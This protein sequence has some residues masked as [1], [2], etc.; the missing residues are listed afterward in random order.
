MFS[1]PFVDKRKLFVMKC[2]SRNSTLF[3][4]RRGPWLVLNQGVETLI[5]AL[6][7][8]CDAEQGCNQ[9]LSS[10]GKENGAVQLEVGSDLLLYILR[11]LQSIIRFDI[12][13]ISMRYTENI[14]VIFY[15]QSYKLRCFFAFYVYVVSKWPIEYY[16]LTVAFYLAS[17]NQMIINGYKKICNGFINFVCACQ[18]LE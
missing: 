9:S 5:H 2:L 15:S 11:S 7:L 16:R 17:Q 6:W 10:Q 4:S 12:W 14:Q 13:R 3:L 8:S 18:F 1:F